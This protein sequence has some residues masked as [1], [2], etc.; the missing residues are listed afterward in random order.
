MK[1]GMSLIVLVIT[2]LVMIILA[3][4]VV[5]SL[6]AN[7]PID[8]AKEARFKTDIS[9]FKTE[10]NTTM[11]SHLT[12]DRLLAKKDINASKA[13]MKEYIPSMGD[14]YYNKIEII[15][16]ELVFVGES[17]QEKK[18]GKA[19]GLGSNVKGGVPQ[20]VPG[21]SPIKWDYANKEESTSEKDV[22]WYDYE[23][24]RWA[25]AKT[26]NGSYYVWIP[27]F[28]YR[29]KY[30]RGQMDMLKD[31][32]NGI[33]G[34]SDN[35][36]LVDK[37]GILKPN[38]SKE[39]G[40]VDIVILGTGSANLYKFLEGGKYVGDVR[41]SGGVDNPNSYIVHPAFSPVRRK[42]QDGNARDNYGS[43]RELTGFWMAKFEMSDGHKSVPGNSSDRNISI[44][45]A[46]IKGKAVADKEKI[47]GADSMNMT[48]TQFG[49]VMYLTNAIGKEPTANRNTSFQTGGGDID[50]FKTNQKQSTTS[51]ITGVY[52]INGG[53]A[54]YVSAYISNGNSSL[55]DN[56][57][58]LQK[59]SSTRCVDVYSS[60]EA[61]TDI[62]NYKINAHKYGDAIYETSTSVNGTYT[63]GID[64][65][66][67]GKAYYPA[68]NKVAFYRSNSNVAQ[69]K[70]D[71]YS[72]RQSEGQSMSD[73]SWRCV[74]ATK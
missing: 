47:T 36:G 4:V 62:E 30:Y 39:Y 71:L 18:W 14:E 44:S 69:N 66:R 59:N 40:K 73:I 55:K 64:G 34:Y 56:C 2:V 1:K 10:I 8:K 63:W 21:L 9:N 41:K 26:T 43:D 58:E 25:N 11:L 29:I 49:A 65:M 45:E 57:D 19:L 5:V 74:L 15:N 28:A 70:N 22:K 37:S 61:D 48:S 7:N 42:D 23:D 33:I 24:K 68:K 31:D 51:N 17:E 12:E 52:D 54:E 3:G 20:L 46:F 27:R 16:G 38:L 35:R 32:E 60:S 72:F 53:S 50:A 13:G 67:Y 6:S